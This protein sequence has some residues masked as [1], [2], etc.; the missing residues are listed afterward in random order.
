MEFAFLEPADRNGRVMIRE[1]VAFW[2][3]YADIGRPG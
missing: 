2:E 3:S 1:L